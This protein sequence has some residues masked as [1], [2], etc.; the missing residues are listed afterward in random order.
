VIVSLIVAM[1]ENRG[2]G[3]RGGLPWH[4]STDLK[5][6][7]SLTMGHHILMGRKT[8]ESIGRALPGR[9]MIV[10]SRNP[11]YRAVSCLVVQSVEEGLEAA[12]YQEES[13]L[14]IIGGREIFE[15][16]LPYAMRIYLTQVHTAGEADTFFPEINL[17][18]WWVVDSSSYPAGENDDFPTTFKRFESKH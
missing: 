7:K 8:F 16:A 4:L 18:D 6:F 11:D 17:D 3:L 2:I 10:V 13:E 15:Q 12:R 9:E 1:D 5:R 14:F